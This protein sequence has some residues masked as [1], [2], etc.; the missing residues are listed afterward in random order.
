ME[1]D[2]VRQDKTCYPENGQP[3][4]RLSDEFRFLVIRHLVVRLPIWLLKQQ[5]GQ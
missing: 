2:N 1:I 3:E 4:R 5:A